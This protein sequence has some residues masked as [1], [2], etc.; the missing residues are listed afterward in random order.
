MLK[1]HNGLKNH[2][3]EISDIHYDFRNAN[4][5]Q[6]ILRYLKGQSLLDI[7]C[8]PGHFIYLAKQCGYHATGI[9]PDD[10]LI[11]LAKKLYPTDRLN[12]KWG[13][14]EDLSLEKTVDNITMIDVL[15][16]IKQDKEI[17]SRLSKHLSSSGRI[18]LVVPSHPS[19][20][21]LRDHSVGHYRRYTK[22]QLRELLSNCG[23][24]IVKLRHWNALGVIPFYISE[25]VLR[26][27]LHTKIRNTKKQKGLN[28]L[29]AK[30]LFIWFKFVEGHINFR[31]GLSLICVAEVKNRK[32]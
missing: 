15:E 4:L 16:H 5:Y 26:R 1:T 14:A 8:G 23:M 29:L 25:K 20:Y 6:L 31:F 18:I 32:T 24:N 2:Y 7:G 30:S 11:R 17:L 10:S 28:S 12:I 27:P 21:G 13:S 19:L 9:E 3:T 22:S